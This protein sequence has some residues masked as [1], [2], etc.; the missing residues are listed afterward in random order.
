MLVSS[1]ATSVRFLTS[2]ARQ[3]RRYCLLGSFKICWSFYLKSLIFMRRLNSSRHCPTSNEQWSYR[4]SMK[5]TA[6]YPSW[7]TSIAHLN[8]P[9]TICMGTTG[10]M[11]K[12]SGT[13]SMRWIAKSCSCIQNCSSW[14][15]RT[16]GGMLL[17]WEVNSYDYNT[18]W[19]ATSEASRCSNSA[20]IRSPSTCEHICHL[21]PISMGSLCLMPTRMSS[22]IQ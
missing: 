4:L 21:K 8:M 7:Y 16:P 5:S 1:R 22:K 12:H 20:K 19:L 6:C 2:S 17:I 13:R 15:K 3:N 14:L 9:P 18:K 10:L 11:F